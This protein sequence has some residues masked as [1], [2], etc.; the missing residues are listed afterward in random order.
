MNR[1]NAKASFWG[2]S[3]IGRKGLGY[4]PL[5]PLLVYWISPVGIDRIPEMNN[6]HG[7]GSGY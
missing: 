5:T 7:K 6:H 2:M 4:H 3:N 1:S